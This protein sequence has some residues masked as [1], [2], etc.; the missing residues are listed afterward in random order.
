MERH[1]GQGYRLLIELQGKRGVKGSGRG[2]LDGVGFFYE[3]KN[4]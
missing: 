1:I 4:A 2:Y 3:L